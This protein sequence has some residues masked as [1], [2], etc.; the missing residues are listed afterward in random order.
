MATTTASWFFARCE[1]SRMRKRIWS[2]A[3][4]RS[5]AADTSVRDTSLT[6]RTGEVSAVSASPCPS[7]RAWPA[8]RSIGR[9][10]A[11]PRRRASS[12]VSRRRPSPTPTSSFSEFQS[13]ASITAAGTEAVALH[14]DSNDRRTA[15]TI[16]PSLPAKVTGVSGTSATGP[17]V[18]KVAGFPVSS[19]PVEATTTPVRST[20]APDQPGSSLSW[21]MIGSRLPAFRVMT[22]ARR[23]P[24]SVV[25]GRATLNT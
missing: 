23:S 8:S 24:V 6:S 25:T 5:A 18:R 10:T 22:S 21:R 11:C 15:S 9:D 4:F 13:G 2:S 20:R 3:R 7:A 12:P 14:P 19:A 1:S 16:S 17:A